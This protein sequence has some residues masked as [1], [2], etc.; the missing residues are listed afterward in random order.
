[1]VFDRYPLGTSI[2]RSLDLTY[3]SIDRV[4]RKSGC[5]TTRLPAKR[6]PSCPASLRSI[7]LPQR[8][9]SQNFLMVSRCISFPPSMKLSTSS[10][11]WPSDVSSEKNNVNKHLSYGY[12]YSLQPTN[13]Q[14]SLPSTSLVPTPVHKSLF[15]HATTVLDPLLDESL[16]V[17]VWW[18]V[19]FFLT[20]CEPNVGQ[21]C[22]AASHLR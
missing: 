19:W 12:F 8:Y 9:L 20:S 4:M 14:S 22:Y 21:I 16:L 11:N 17:A 3:S 10:N 15:Q 2:G 7:A 1:M 6:V 5:C 18:Q 13:P